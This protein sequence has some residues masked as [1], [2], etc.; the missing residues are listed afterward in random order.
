MEDDARVAFHG[1]L[2]PILFGIDLHRAELVERERLSIATVA[3]AVDP[4]SA[5]FDPVGQFDFFVPL[6]AVP[7][8]L[9]Q[10]QTDSLLT[11]DDRPARSQSHGNGHQQQDRRQQDQHRRG[12]HNIVDPLQQPSRLTETACVAARPFQ[13][14]SSQPFRRREV[15]VRNIVVKQ[16]A[17]LVLCGQDGRFQRGRTHGDGSSHQMSSRPNGFP[18]L[19]LLSNIGHAPENAARSRATR[20]QFPNVNDP[21]AATMPIVTPP[22]KLAL[23]LRD[24]RREEVAAH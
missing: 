20:T 12:D 8:L 9:T 13:A 3:T 16:I 10:V 5:S 18:P 7:F 15:V 22:A 17:E 14:E 24:R 21:I 23:S 4:R 11:E 2:S 1:K 19:A 6:T